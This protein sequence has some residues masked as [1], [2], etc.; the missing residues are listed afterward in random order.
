MIDAAH[1]GVVVVRPQLIREVVAHRPWTIGQRVVRRVGRRHAI[2]PSGWDLIVRERRSRAA[3]GHRGRIEDLI[4]EL[5]EVAASHRLGR[6]GV[7]R[8]LGLHIPQVLERGHEERAVPHHRSAERAGVAVVLARRLRPVVADGEQRCRGAAVAAVE[9]AGR[10]VQRVGPALHGE[11][12]HR[13]RG[14]AALRVERVGLHLELFDRVGRR[15]EPH[16]A[17][18]R[19][20]GRSV[21]GELVAT[22]H[23]VGHDAGEVA[24]VGGSGKVQ[25]GRV[26]DAGRQ[27]REHVGGAVAERQL[28]NLLAVHRGAADAGA[29]VEQRAF[30][31]HRDGLGDAAGLEDDV[32]ADDVADPHLV[33]DA[34][35]LLEAG[36][37]GGDA[38]AAGIEI[39]D[40][41]SSAL[42]GD[43]VLLNGR[44][45]VG[46]GD[47]HTGQHA[48]GRIG[49]RSLD[50]SPELLGGG[51]SR[52]HDDDPHQHQRGHTL[53]RT[54]LT[55]PIHWTA[56]PQGRT[57]RGNTTSNT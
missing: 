21:D 7:G 27:A 23:A 10:Q 47:R 11:I 6:D 46:D 30:G 44:S 54:H 1:A 51:E 28:R 4:A 3:G 41:V 17:R 37:L 55:P 20:V 13:P 56:Q 42:V 16:A 12:D 38:V 8:R 5:A 40:A 57:V 2:D 19:H 45:R 18:V 22:L 29:G 33:V 50:G 52:T 14:V 25:V 36:E 53:T 48:A 9:V 31:G 43:N 49:H 26:H 15:R 34:D 24:V 32:H 35:E 39:Q